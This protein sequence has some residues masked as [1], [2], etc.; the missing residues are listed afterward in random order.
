MGEYR[1]EYA[2][3][4]DAV[5]AVCPS[6]C[7]DRS[8]I[9]RRG[10][11]DHVSWF[12]CRAQNRI[13]AVGPAAAIGAVLLISRH[14]CTTTIETT[15]RHGVM[16]EKKIINALLCIQ[17]IVINDDAAFH[18]AATG[19]GPYNVEWLAEE[20]EYEEEEEEKEEQEEEDVS[21]V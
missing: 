5:C 6:V 19:A 16:L 13:N 8:S 10:C 15:A 14:K 11:L 2:E 17:A 3:E 21:A 9:I 4:E 7:L 1:E 18:A 20:D 12:A